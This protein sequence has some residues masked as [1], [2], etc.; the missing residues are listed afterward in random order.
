MV[1][2]SIVAIFLA[3]L[4]IA[5]TVLS[6]VYLPPGAA[7]LALVALLPLGIYT[8]LFVPAFVGALAYMG[9][10]RKQADRLRTGLQL[11]NDRLKDAKLQQVGREEWDK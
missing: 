7:Q 9:D 8:M 1:I 10:F 4:T 2:G 5:G 6:A 3:F 11:A